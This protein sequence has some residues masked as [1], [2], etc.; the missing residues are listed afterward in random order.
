MS[1]I[2]DFTP[3]ALRK[4]DDL[5]GMGHLVYS[6][7]GPGGEIRL[8]KLDENFNIQDE[9]TLVC[10]FGRVTRYR[11]SLDLVKD[12]EDALGSDNSTSRIASLIEGFHKDFPGLLR[13]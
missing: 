11:F 8:Y 4:I 7:P 1:G 5:T 10:P 13:T 2:A 3:V 9:Y 6:V 12:I